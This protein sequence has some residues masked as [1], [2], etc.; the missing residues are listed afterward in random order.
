M[1]RN[2]SEIFKILLVLARSSPRFWEFVWS[3]SGRGFP[4]FL[5][6]GPTAFS[7]LIPF[8]DVDKNLFDD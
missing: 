1:T 2:R 8:Q 7:P 4:I 6:P 5:V 3:L